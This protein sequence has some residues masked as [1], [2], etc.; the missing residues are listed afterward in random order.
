M[1]SALLYLFP[2]LKR[3]KIDQGVLEMHFLLH[4]FKACLSELW[5]CGLC[6]HTCSVFFLCKCFVVVFFPAAILIFSRPG[7]HLFPDINIKCRI[8]IRIYIIIKHMLSTQLQEEL[9]LTR[10]KMGSVQHCRISR[11]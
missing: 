1:A 4:H 5:C 11:L 2:I 6:V 7:R 10:F 8:I 3:N 9:L